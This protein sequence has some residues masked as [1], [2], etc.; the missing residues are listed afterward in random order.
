M[1][2]KEELHYQFLDYVIKNHKPDTV[3]DPVKILQELGL[4]ENVSQAYEIAKELEVDGF[5]EVLTDGIGKVMI[6][7]YKVKAKRFV[8]EIQTLNKVIPESQILNNDLTVINQIIIGNNNN[9]IINKT[10]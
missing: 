9:Q 2:P 7:G 5:L 10:S 1:L 6:E 4:D 3:T 8:Q